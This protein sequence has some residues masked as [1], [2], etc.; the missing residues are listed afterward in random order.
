MKF[1]R[2]EFRSPAKKKKIPIF[3][4]SFRI[5][6][7]FGFSLS[8]AHS[9]KCFWSPIRNCYRT[10]NSLDSTLLNWILALGHVQWV[11]R[12]R[13]PWGRSEE[14]PAGLVNVVGPKSAPV[15]RIRCRTGIWS[16]NGYVF[17]HYRVLVSITWQFHVLFHCSPNLGLL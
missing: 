5:R 1:T 11:H 2:T 14:D 10:L 6:K 16:P 17:S 3:H 12:W 4:R 15:Y 13:E 9:S 7:G 8:D